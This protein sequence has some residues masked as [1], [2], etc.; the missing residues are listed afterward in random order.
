MKNRS[1]TIAPIGYVRTSG[2]PP[3]LE[4]DPGLAPALEGLDGFSHLLVLYWCHLVDDPENR[5][6]R[7]LKKPYTKGPETI[8]V[9][10]P[11]SPAR[12]ALARPLTVPAFPGLYIPTS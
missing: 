8:G 2:G 9:L 12:P 6:R 1:F 7:V 11:R 10:A 5:S 4:I 3:R